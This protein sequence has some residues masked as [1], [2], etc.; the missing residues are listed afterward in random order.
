MS[1]PLPLATQ[2]LTPARWGDSEKLLGPR[3]ASAGWWCMF[4]KL[5]NREYHALPPAFVHTG[6]ASAFCAVS[7]TEAARRAAT[8]PIFRCRI[9]N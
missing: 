6:L 9:E 2:A 8:R 3:R 4:W 5:P 7:V 1:N